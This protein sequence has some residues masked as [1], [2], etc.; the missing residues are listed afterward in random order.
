MPVDSRGCLSSFLDFFYVRWANPASGDLHENLR[1]ANLWNGNRFNPQ[2]IDPA[3]QDGG[4][5]LRKSH[6]HVIKGE[7]AEDLISNTV[8]SSFFVPIK[9]SPL[10]Y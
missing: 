10:K 4:H 8:H 3:V 1:T 7:P 6:R 2:V 5:G 9:L